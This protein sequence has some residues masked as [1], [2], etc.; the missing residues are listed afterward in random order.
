MNNTMNNT[1]NDTILI[2]SSKFRLSRLTWED[3]VRGMDNELARPLVRE[4]DEY[5]AEYK[6]GRIIVA[7]PLGSVGRYIKLL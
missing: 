2:V 3:L 6:D 5:R 4:A 1:M 7:V